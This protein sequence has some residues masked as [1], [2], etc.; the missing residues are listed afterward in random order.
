MVLKS[1]L[2]ALLGTSTTLLLL[3]AS[4]AAAADPPPA[5]VFAGH[6]ALSTFTKEIIVEGSALRLGDGTAAA[7]FGFSIGVFF[8]PWLSLV[9]GVQGGFA[10]TDAR[11]FYDTRGALRFVWPEP[12]GPIFFYG[13]LGV[14]VFFIEQVSGS[15]AFSEAFGVAAG[16]GAFANLGARVRLYVEARDAWLVA[17]ADGLD[18]NLFVTLGVAT[19]FR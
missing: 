1:G 6:P 18:H 12:A 8:A 7:G 17:N 4:R 15:H 13:A 5:P 3:V 2:R 11:Q 19:L 16:L 9:G 10:L 14:D